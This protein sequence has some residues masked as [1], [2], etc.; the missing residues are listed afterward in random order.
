MAYYL[1]NQGLA[2]WIITYVIY[3]ISFVIVFFTSVYNFVRSVDKVETFDDMV[4]IKLSYW[5][6]KINNQE[7]TEKGMELYCVPGHYWFELWIH[8]KDGKPVAPP[9]DPDFD[10]EDD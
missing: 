5:F 8:E 1:P 2:Y 9:D 6:Q 3:G 4:F 10:S 7:L